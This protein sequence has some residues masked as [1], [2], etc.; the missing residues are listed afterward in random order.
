MPFRLLLF[1]ILIAGAGA[2]SHQQYAPNA[3]EMPFLTEKGQS[4]ASLMLGHPDFAGYVDFHA[5]YNPW[6]NVTGMLH[7]QTAAGKVASAFG[8][9]TTNNFINLNYVEGAFGG[10][11]M[12]KKPN[13]KLGLYTGAGH[14]QVKNGYGGDITS[15]LRYNKYFLQPTLLFQGQ[16]AHFG[17][18][19]RLSNLAF[20]KGEVD[21]AIPA[22]DLQEIGYIGDRSPFTILEAGLQMGFHFKPFTWILAIQRSKIYDSLEYYQLGFQPNSVLLGCKLNLN[23]LKRKKRTSPPPAPNE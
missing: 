2:C 14:G 19:I 12:L 18:G 7:Y 3:I 9:F 8:N 20:N 23:E 6:R 4:S 15:N 11:F 16:I 1:A 17:L 21:V 13:L 5:A 22:Q 10:K